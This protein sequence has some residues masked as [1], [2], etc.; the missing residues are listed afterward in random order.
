MKRVFGFVLIGLGAFLLVF[1]PAVK[2]V[3]APALAVA[4][5]ACDPGPLCDD[6]V[7][8]SPS[9]GV[10]RVLFDPG[11]LSPR[12]NVDLL[13]VRRVKADVEA[14]EGANNQTVYDSFQDVTD[15]EGVTVTAST[16][17]IAFNGHT[18]EMIN[19][20][21]SVEGDEPITDFAGI[22]P[23][24]FGFGTQKQDYLYFDGTLATALPMVFD[25]TDEVLGLEAYRF[26]QTIE[27]TQYAE[28]E[29]PGE[30][31]DQPDEAS[32]VAPRFYANVRTVW[33]EPTTG[34][35]LRGQE[36]Q[37]Q[38]LA[39][40]DGSSEAL[41]LLDATLAWT[42]ENVANAV[43]NASDGKSSLNLI[44]QTIPLVAVLLGLLA[45]VG[46]WFLLRRPAG[47]GA[48]AA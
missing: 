1:G 6:G 46:G 11:T 30:L 17:R 13:S 2:W 22:A 8:L 19:C 44:Q 41:L 39:G 24:K 34:A 20:C 16:E 32:V 26:V 23:Y 45:L 4:P 14:S 9:S 35:I 7:S 5:L 48:A 15:P 27:A 18:S 12:T 33:V 29:V 37:R 3:V 43:E 31:V 47:D 40:A 42:D 36:V 28:L 38:F 10:A 21:D 25:G